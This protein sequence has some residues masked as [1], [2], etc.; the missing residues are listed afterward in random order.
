MKIGF[1]LPSSG[2][3]AHVDGLLEVATRAK[4]LGIESLW[5]A[6]HIVAPT[7]VTSPYPFSADGSYHNTPMTRYLEPLTTLAFIA[8]AVPDVDLVV[9]VLVLPYRHPLQTA[10][11][12]ATLDV[13]SGGR[14]ILG[15]GVGWMQEEFE[16]LGHGYFARRGANTDEQLSI[17]EQAWT[18]RPFSHDGPFYKFDE[19]VI[20]PMPV[21]QPLR[22]WV[23]GHAEPAF[24]RAVRFGEALNC[25]AEAPEEIARISGRL[26]DLSAAAERSVPPA[27][28]L[29]G[30]VRVA[31]AI[32]EARPGHLIGPIEYIKERLESYAQLGVPTFGIDNR[33]DGLA[34]MLENLEAIAPLLES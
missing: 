14:L 12:A 19:V 16:A 15:V 4:G 5:V 2:D 27:I 34:G 32:D 6:D 26:I 33:T 8:G 21:Q 7:N 29:R 17:L 30:H 25:N 11:I 28:T 20:Q 1:Y 9:S 31:R 22:I 13:L 3:G 24:R 10:K 23:A 18:G